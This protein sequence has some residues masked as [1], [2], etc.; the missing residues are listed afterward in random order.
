MHTNISLQNPYTPLYNLNTI[1]KFHTIIPE[2]TAHQKII[3][4]N[5]RSPF[6]LFSLCTPR[7]F[8]TS[9]HET[10]VYIL[11]YAE[12][13]IRKRYPFLIDLIQNLLPLL[14]IT[15]QQDQFYKLDNFC[16]Q[17]FQQQKRQR[18]LIRF[19][20]QQ[21]T[22]RSYQQ[23]KYTTKNY[24]NRFLYQYTELLQFQKCTIIISIIALRNIQN[25]QCVFLSTISNQHINI[26]QHILKQLLNNF[27]RPHLQSVVSHI[28]Q[29]IR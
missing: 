16:N 29:N 27:L 8:T 12:Q 13:F 24:K 23:C 20:H 15:L 22:M 5:I 3:K 9:L 26:F 25:I 1:M 14:V 28:I 11:Y 19:M 7:S 2:Y 17:S 4:Q 21:K 10:Y 18:I 6:I